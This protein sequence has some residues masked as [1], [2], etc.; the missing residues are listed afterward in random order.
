MPDIDLNQLRQ[1]VLNNQT[2]G[3]SQPPSDDEAVF[4]TP[5]GTVQVGNQ[6]PG[7]STTNRGDRTLT[8][9]SP[10]IFASVR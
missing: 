6:A 9:L 1:T 10:T 7:G 2:R 5:E 3:P 4:I 8:K